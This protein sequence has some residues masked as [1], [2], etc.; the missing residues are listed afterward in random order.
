MIKQCAKVILF[1]LLAGG[2]ILSCASQ[3]DT[4][5]LNN[6]INAIQRQTKNERV[7][8]E[9]TIE[10]LKEAFAASENKSMEIEK[11]LKEGQESLRLS[12]TQILTDM[13]EIKEVVQSLTGTVEENRHLIKSALE[14]DITKEDS[15]LFQIKELLRKVDDLQSRLLNIEARSSSGVSP[16]KKAGGLRN[17]ATPD[18]EQ[19]AAV[20]T[21][22]K[23]QTESDI[24]NEM[25]GYYKSGSYKKALDGFKE[26]IKLYPKSSLADNAAFWTG[27]CYKG[28]ESYEEAILAYQK[29]IDEYPKGNKVP[30]AILQQAVS[31]EKINDNTTAKL[32]LKKLIKNFP[33]SKEAEIA[34]KKLK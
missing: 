17:Q 13:E 23:P 6:K 3:E 24:Y 10:N 30:A 32:L 14:V 26:F 31:F 4:V 9:N 25:L 20:S 15:K 7:E 12:L 18:K 11:K 29:V 5:Y 34:S 28:L 1:V 2:L 22:K 21:E 19:K 8:L 27:E 16:G 33:N